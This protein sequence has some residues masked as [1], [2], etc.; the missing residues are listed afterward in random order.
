MQQLHAKCLK[1]CLLALNLVF[2][3]LG[4]IILMLGFWFRFDQ[5]TRSLFEIDENA[6]Q[7]SVGIYVMWAAGSLLLAAGFTGYL[8]VTRQYRCM[9]WIY[10]GFLIL[11][12]LIEM[13]VAIWAF[14]QKD[15]VIEQ[16]QTTYV[17]T[18]ARGNA[19]DV[20]FECMINTIHKTLDCCGYLDKSGHQAGCSAPAQYKDCGKA[21]EETINSKLHIFAAIAFGIALVTVLGIILTIFFRRSIKSSRV[22]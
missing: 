20:D 3:L 21:I 9:I 18:A 13:G 10:L 12:F 6:K 11:L 16:L 1:Y 22:V 17:K 4:L 2:A 15:Q 5:R 8:S 7:L 14:V 19:K